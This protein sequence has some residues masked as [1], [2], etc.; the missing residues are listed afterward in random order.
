MPTP[1]PT[2]FP[3]MMPPPGHFDPSIMHP[4]P[5]PMDEKFM[6]KLPEIPNPA[7]FTNLHIPVGITMDRIKVFLQKYKEH[8][9]TLVQAC[10]LIRFP[11]VIIE[12]F[13]VI[14]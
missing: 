11:D 2:A 1:I 14:G 5:P 13:I 10:Q 6:I 4:M 3:P 8:Q 9:Q 12:A 7:S